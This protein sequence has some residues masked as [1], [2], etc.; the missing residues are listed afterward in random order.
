MA[1]VTA[2]K[3]SA[4]RR[5]HKHC[6][7]RA[8]C[9]DRRA[10]LGTS[11]VSSCVLVAA[12]PIGAVPV[13]A[14]YARSAPP[15][16]VAITMVIAIAMAVRSISIV[17]IVALT[18]PPA[19]TIIVISLSHGRGGR[20]QNDR[21]RYCQPNPLH[22]ASPLC[23][24]ALGRKQT[25]ISLVPPAPHDLIGTARKEANSTR[26]PGAY[27]VLV[28]K[29]CAAALAREELRNFFT[30]DCRRGTPAALQ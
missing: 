18:A 28:R 29:R 4:Q 23:T 3:T 16:A 21:S 10:D 2:V 9:R 13:I 8:T 20:G 17:T 5:T 11:S 27:C 7:V 1:A 22:H 6:F 24:G 30:W 12:T 19:S 14:P 25:A 15:V 26:E